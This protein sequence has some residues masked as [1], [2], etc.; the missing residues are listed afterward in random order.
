MK[1]PRSGKNSSP[2]LLAASYAAMQ[3]PAALLAMED[4]EV[5]WNVC[6]LQKDIEFLI[7]WLK[8]KFIFSN[9]APM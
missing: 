5:F 8:Q 6:R 1:L 2:S 9:F 3:T 4:G 7:K